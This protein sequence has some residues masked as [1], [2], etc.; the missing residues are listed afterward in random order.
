MGEARTGRLR[1]T[2]GVTTVAYVEGRGT[3]ALTDP[4]L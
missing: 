3:L 4:T 2:L 1:S